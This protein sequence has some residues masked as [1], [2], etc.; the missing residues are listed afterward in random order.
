MSLSVNDYIKFDLYNV[1]LMTK[2]NFNVNSLRKAYQ[3]QV[4]VYHPDKR[5]PDT[6]PEEKQEL[7]A[8]FYLINNAYTILSNEELRNT[9]DKL[10]ELEENEEKS[11][12]SLKS[13]YKKEVLEKKSDPE[14]DKKKALAAESFQEKM[15]RMNREKEQFATTGVSK[16]NNEDIIV[17]HRD[18]SGSIN[19]NLSNFQSSREKDNKDIVDHWKST[20]KEEIDEF[21]RSQKINPADNFKS[22]FSNINFKRNEKIEAT[23]K[24]YDGLVNDMGGKYATLDEAFGM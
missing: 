9:Y 17:P 15:D 22:E 21:L 19:K 12:V 24:E 20:S 6:T 13:Q 4:M 1:F 11:F 16:Y 10:R 8:T 23:G 14:A 2:K 18:I 3:R 5:A 7:D